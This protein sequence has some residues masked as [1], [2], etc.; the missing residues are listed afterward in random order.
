MKKK[1][2]ERKIYL[3]CTLR[4]NDELRVSPSVFDAEH[5]YAPVLS[6]SRSVR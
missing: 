6:R 5:K 2:K 3:H 1:K 4:N